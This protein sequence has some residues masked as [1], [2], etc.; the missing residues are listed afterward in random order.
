MFEVVII[1]QY[2]ILEIHRSLLSMYK[3]VYPGPKKKK[4]G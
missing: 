1:V 4:K 2:H 3:M